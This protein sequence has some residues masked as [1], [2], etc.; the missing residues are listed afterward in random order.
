[1][2][3][4][5]QDIWSLTQALICTPTPSSQ[6]DH[7]GLVLDDTLGTSAFCSQEA[8]FSLE[9]SVRSSNSDNVCAGGIT[10]WGGR[11]ETRRGWVLDSSLLTWLYFQSEVLPFLIELSTIG[12][13]SC[14]PV[15][16]KD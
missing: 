9:A 11:V 5:S 1:M 6:V 7:H 14:V 12:A 3:V 8:L 16:Y 13:D 4:K 15:L 2:T 10:V